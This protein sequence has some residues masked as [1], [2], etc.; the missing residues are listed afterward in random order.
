M[1]KNPRAFQH[2][3]VSFD[4]DGN[5]TERYLEPATPSSPKH[6]Y[7]VNHNGF[8][9]PNAIFADNLAFVQCYSTKNSV[10]FVFKSLKNDRKYY[11]FLS[12]FEDILKHR[13]LLDGYRI[14]GEFVF[15]KKG[16]SQGVRMIIE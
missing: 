8:N 10:R 7:R 12:D 1:N 15:H 5:L 4:Q 16:N 14:Q 3:E 11:M 6:F 9:E 13:K 2:Y